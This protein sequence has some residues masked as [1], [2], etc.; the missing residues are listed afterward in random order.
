M[1]SDPTAEQVEFRRKGRQ[2]LI[3]AV[4]LAVAAV[5]F[6]PMLLDP[7]PRRERVEPLLAIPPRDGAPPLMPA[8]AS[9][10]PVARPEP[11]KVPLNQAPG[12]AAAPTPAPAQEASPESRKTVEPRTSEFKPAAPRAPSAKPEPK[13]APPEPKLEGFAVQVGAFKD[14]SVLAQAREKVASTRLPHYAE[15]LGG[16]AGELTRLR[17][18]PF[19]TREAAD[20]AAARLKRA[21]LPDARVVPLP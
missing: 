19:P 21:G 9:V 14:E 12:P 6:V 20:T 5:V 1:P 18:G 3:G 4:V 8:T 10:E 11:A 17:A 15:R 16:D 13:P 7:E 2:R